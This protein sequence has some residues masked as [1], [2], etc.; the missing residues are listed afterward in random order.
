MDNQTIEP[1]V[2]EA[3]APAETGPHFGIAVEHRARLATAVAAVAA[4]MTVAWFAR[5]LQSDGVLAWAWCVVL[6]AVAVVQLLVVR[7]SRAPILLADD[8]GVR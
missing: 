7:D 1:T 4:V 5:A 2:A 8:H 3:P 6:G